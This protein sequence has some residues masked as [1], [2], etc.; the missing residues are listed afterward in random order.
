MEHTSGDSTIGGLPVLSER[1]DLG[2]RLPVLPLARANA[3]EATLPAGSMGRVARARAG[4]SG[5]CAGLVGA[6]SPRIDVECGGHA[7]GATRPHPVW[8]VCTDS[9]PHLLGPS[10]RRARDGVGSRLSLRADR[11]RIHPAGP[12]A[13]D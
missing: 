8:A 11:I 4:L 5:S 1:P 9:P 3:G 6:D 2:G 12:D 10:A 7:Q 13:E